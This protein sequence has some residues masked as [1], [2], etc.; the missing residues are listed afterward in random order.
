TARLERT[1][2]VTAETCGKL[3]DFVI[4]GEH[5]ALDKSLLEEMADPLLHLIRNAI[6]QG[7]EPS[8][9]RIAAG[10]PE[11]GRITVRAQHEG[12]DV[13]IEVADDGGGLN[14]ERIRRTAVERGL[15]GEAEAALLA[16]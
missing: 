13:L 12:T 15:L 14:A 3:V 16:P 11:R 5:V 4:E 9:A 10:K 1:V 7:I 2:R 8:A 6:D